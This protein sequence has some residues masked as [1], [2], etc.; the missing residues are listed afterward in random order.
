[1]RE[2][3]GQTSE[4]MLNTEGALDEPLIEELLRYHRED[5]SGMYKEERENYL[6]HVEG[7][8]LGK[9]NEQAEVRVAARRFLDTLKRG[10]A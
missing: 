8:A 3:L 7:M 4:E 5:I 6:K 2:T 10:E 1:M 9:N